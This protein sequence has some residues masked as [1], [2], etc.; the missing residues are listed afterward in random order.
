V[1]ILWPDIVG[2][3]GVA[4]VVGATGPRESAWRWPTK[5][6]GVPGSGGWS[7]QAQPEHSQAAP[8]FAEDHLHVLCPESCLYGEFP[9][10]RSR[11]PDSTGL[12]GV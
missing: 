9:R 10:R 7:T 5:V 12:A 8:W 4:L 11:A 2:T 1:N 3:V 6:P